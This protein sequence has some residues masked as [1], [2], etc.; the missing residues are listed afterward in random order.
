MAVSVSGSIN[1]Q[2]FYKGK[3]SFNM[4]LLRMQF[5]K[6]WDFLMII[7]PGFKQQ[8]CIRVENSQSVPSMDMYTRLF[9]FIVAKVADRYRFKQKV[10]YHTVI[11]ISLERIE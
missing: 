4:K 5:A 1:R 10:L 3:D 2:C 8:S 6:D 7:K 9:T 11:V